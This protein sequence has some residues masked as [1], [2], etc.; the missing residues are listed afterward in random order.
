MN[1]TPTE[2]LRNTTAGISELNVFKLLVRVLTVRDG[3]AS[4]GE[5]L[6]LVF[7][8]EGEKDE[9]LTRGTIEVNRAYG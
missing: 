3:G 5:H 6:E 2:A 4:E 1:S 8:H 7:E 9:Q